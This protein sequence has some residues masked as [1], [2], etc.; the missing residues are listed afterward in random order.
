MNKSLNQEHQ[1]A[2]TS[3]PLPSIY[4]GYQ[5][6]V[7]ASAASNVEAVAAPMASAL[8]PW[9]RLAQARQAGGWTVNTLADRLKLSP[10][11]IAALESGA[12]ATLPKGSLLKAM[13]RSYCRAINID[14]NPYLVE[15]PLDST[16]LPVQIQPVKAI[17]A[18]FKRESSQHHA[19][20]Q[21]WWLWLLLVL[22]L[23]AGWIAY[24]IQNQSLPMWMA[25]GDNP[26]QAAM[27]VAPVTE[28]TTAGAPT[29]PS[30]APGETAE[31]TASVNPSASPP[32]AVDT[33]VASSGPLTSTVTTA[34]P[35]ERSAPV[36]PV[37]SP[38]SANVVPATSTAIAASP[39]PANPDGP[40]KTEAASS[41]TPP[42][43][44]PAPN[45]AASLQLVF[46]QASWVE[47]RQAN[48]KV[49]FSGLRKAGEKEQV[50]GLAPLNVVVGNAAGVEL[51]YR[52]QRVELPVENEKNV[53]R[54]TLE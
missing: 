40:V 49:V 29:L 4:E 54:L 14:P 8:T 51:R 39:R 21:A 12:W 2:F 28:S 16:D 15:L 38:P 42:P 43:P 5:F 48:G 17:E 27:N 7:A 53:A 20:T 11:Q 19:K 24:A 36:T 50:E 31:G 3:S 30:T 6:E 23:V 44:S 52:G 9:Q 33:S 45:K 25:W 10:K 1:P 34:L 32:S 37:A 13:L 35:P 46:K 26:E 22:L 18:P 41:V 47:V